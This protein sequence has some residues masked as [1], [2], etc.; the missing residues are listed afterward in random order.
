MTHDPRRC[1][2]DGPIPEEEAD[3]RAAAERAVERQAANLP[4]VRES[5][6]EET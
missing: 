2:V 1:L 6:P 4:P 5:R 3:V